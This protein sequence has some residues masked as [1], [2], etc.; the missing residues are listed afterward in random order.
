MH[1][2]VIEC[3]ILFSLGVSSVTLASVTEEDTGKTCVYVHT[4]V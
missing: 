3:N 2:T 1:M 4:Y